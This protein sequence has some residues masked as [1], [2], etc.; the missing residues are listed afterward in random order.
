M[1]IAVCL[2]VL[3]EPLLPFTAIKMKLM[4]KIDLS[5]DEVSTCKNPLIKVGNL[6]GKTELLFGKIEDDEIKI[7]LEKLKY[8]T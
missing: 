7:Q 3:S 6:L 1:Q 4:L 8:N 2:A 5:W